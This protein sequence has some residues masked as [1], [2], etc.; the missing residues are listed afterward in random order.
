[1]ALAREP[2]AIDSP[3]GPT[4]CARPNDRS[5]VTPSAGQPAGRLAPV[6]V[7]TG[8]CRIAVLGPLVLEHDGVAVS[9]PRGRQRS[10][11]ALLAMGDGTPLTRDR[12]IDELWGERPPPSAA[13]ALHVHL[14]KV[15]LLLGD[16]LVRDASGYALA[17]GV[18]LD[19]HRFEELV[20]QARREPE[21][22]RELLP[23]ALA[24]FRGE[25]LSD[26]EPVGSLAP[27]RQRLEDQR[28][29]AINLRIEAEL[30]AGAGSEVV[31][32]LQ[33]LV[34]DNPFDERL[35]GHLML[36]LYRAGRSVDALDAFREMRERLVDELGLEPGEPLHRLQQQILD[37]AP[38]LLAAAQAPV[39][40]PRETRR[41]SAL[42]RSPT[43]LVGRDAELA[44][45]IGI[46][47]DPDVRLLTLTGPGG[48]G[49]TRL[50]L[51]LA[52]AQEPHY[53]DGAVLVRL[54]R[55]TDPAQVLPEIAAALSR[56]DGT[57]GLC[58]E[59]VLIRYLADREVLLVLDNFEHLLDAAGPLTGLLA[60]APGVQAIVSSRVALRLRGEQLFE[61][62]PLALP[63][64]DG[65]RE[66]SESPAV[67][68]Y[69]QSALA[70]DRRLELEPETMATIAAICRGLDGLPL[71]IELAAARCQTLTPAQIALQL[72][73][74]LGIGEHALRDLPERQQTLRGAIA[75]SYRLLSP[76]AQGALRAAGVF[77]GG[78]AVDAL[79]AVLGRPAGADLQELVEAC[80]VQRRGDRCAM[81]ELVRTFALETAAAHG[82]ADD[83]HRSHRRF[84]AQFLA[85]IRA[86][87]DRNEAMG[88]IP[89]PIW[90]DHPNCRAA[91]LDAIE[92]DDREAAVGLALGMRALWN[93]RFLREESGEIL[94]RL[95]AR[96]DLDPVDEF[97]LLRMLTGLDSTGRWQRRF[98][99]R[100][101]EVGDPDQIG[102]ALISSF[103]VAMNT[104]DLQELGRLRPA[105]EALEAPG[106]AERVRAWAQYLLS[107]DAYIAADYAQ[108]LERALLVV[109]VT[110]G[111]GNPYMVAS[112][113]LAVAV[114]R[115]ALEG[116]LRQ[117]DV[118]A[119]LHHAS[120]HGDDV[121]AV[122]ALWLAVGYAASVDPASAVRWLVHAEHLANAF[123]LDPWPESI[124]REESMLALGLSEISP[125]ADPD[126]WTGIQATVAEAGDW[127]AARDPSETMPRVP[128][129]VSVAGLVDG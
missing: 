69:A 36:A 98:A 85:P 33:R 55:L 87:L 75:W 50:L 94:E 118:A 43:R 89:A 63:A 10:L 11:L 115:S 90:D 113:V 65:A 99:E 124:L 71:A 125:L 31:I 34:Q 61:L 21:R 7:T 35:C 120:L 59:A 91:L 3:L 112:V 56:R 79:S 51:E 39:M 1:M 64:G 20:E 19:T 5:A 73:Q 18:Q 48:V 129:P 80:L 108:A 62:A 28:F 88:D 111:L 92:R 95:F 109:P 15:R 23:E 122:I 16:V 82:D 110:Q 49:K 60:E 57:E 45:L 105:L 84:F 123:D 38:S 13:S 46:M 30:A 77:I 42:P 97:K 6:T 26:V 103:G 76:G 37:G 2:T 41:A 53:G 106:N 101:A 44:S 12:L 52:R 9:V 127:I 58:D 104:R 17:P 25:P 78:F 114:A 96:F 47:A 8:V 14:S 83:L 126:S 29:H 102:M 32:E 4:H 40:P 100:A 24:L 67:Q 66:I 128:R 68:L 93:G 27:W 116:A 22:A 121:V 74:P 72:T 86:G 54:E 107:A 117:T 119:A 70:V 81:L